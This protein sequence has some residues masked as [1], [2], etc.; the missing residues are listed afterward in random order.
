M[1]SPICRTVPTSER[2]VCTSYCSILVLR[3]WV[4]SSGRSCN[5]F[6]FLSRR[7]EFSSQPLEAA[8]HARVDAQ[9]ARLQDDAADQARVDR[10]R[11]LDGAAG[12]ALDLVEDLSR[13]VVRQLVRCR[14]LDAEPALQLCDE[15]LELAVDLAEL[16]GAVLLDRHQQEVPEELVE[17][18]NLVDHLD[19]PA[20]VVLDLFEV[21]ALLRGLEEGACVRAVG[22]THVV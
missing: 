10:P 17:L 7:R 6:S 22:D 5:G 3:I 15:A 19:E 9:R 4:I 12:R 8:A 20:E 21:V 18:G 13:L 14:E 16:P 2:S 1:P 11:R